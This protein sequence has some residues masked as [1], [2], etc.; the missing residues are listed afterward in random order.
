MSRTRRTIGLFVVLAVVLAACGSDSKSGE[1]GKTGTSTPSAG[2]TPKS[3]SGTLVVGAEQEMDCADWIASC[4]GASWGVWTYQQHTM[5]RVWDYLKV[6]GVWTNVPNVMMA[7]A[8]SV[9]DVGGVQTVT[10]KINPAAVWSDGEPITS[11]D[12][13]YS[14][15]AIAKGKDVYD[16]T[17][18]DKIKSIDTS[19]PKTA[20]VAFKEAYGSWP[21]LFGGLYG[22]FPSHLLAGK[23]RT[24]I[25]SNGYDF[26]GGP[27]IGTWH[28][29]VDV[30]L[31]PNPN[32]YGPKP[33]LAK[34]IFRF[35]ADTSAEFQAFKNGEVLAI[36]PQPQLDAVD[37][38]SEGL[39]GAQSTYTPETGN[40]EALWMNNSKFPFDSLAVRQAF[41][42][43]LDRDAIV[44]RLFGGLGV[45]KAAQSLNAPILSEYSDGSEYAKYTKDLSKVDSLMTGDGW[46][47]NGKGVWAKGKKTASI[48]INTTTDNQ[49]RELTE[50]IVQQQ[51]GEAGFDVKIKNQDAATLFGETGPTGKFQLALYAQV[52]TSLEPGLCGIMCA[53]NVPSKAN[54]NS[55]QNWTRTKIPALDPLLETV[56]TTTDRAARIAAS[57]EADRIMGEN[58]VTLPIDPLPNIGLW[59]ERIT[60]VNGDNPIFSIFWNLAEWDL[61]S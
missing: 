12:F 57:K 10:Y 48:T 43:S 22:V 50:Q 38:I 6:N 45:T 58:M 34:V 52:V 29:G 41:A 18:Y 49:R 13:K 37:Q 60:G 44:N 25:M 35:L 46:K 16:K 56:E 61:A 54:D 42:F 27:W 40:L 30:T 47:K 26:S 53:K 11:E 59:S 31:T 55:G 21:L 9:A 17:G 15:E 32:W 7:A 23:N 19:D 51:A 20:V 8:P 3:G 1:S 24:K 39:E 28:R 2:P 4:A 14:W 36:Y 5:P 33:K